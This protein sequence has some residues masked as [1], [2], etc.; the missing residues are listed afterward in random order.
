MTRLAIKVEDQLFDVELD[1]SPFGNC[2][3]TARVD[4]ECVCISLPPL[5]GSL[6][7]ANWV[8]VNDRPYEITV[9]PELHWIQSSLGTFPLEIRDLG[10]LAHRLCRGNGVVKAPIPGKVVRLLVEP[11]QPVAAGQALVILEAMKMENQILAS[12]EGVVQSVNVS[13]G[14]H[15]ARGDILVEVE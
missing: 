2:H 8:V 13:C 4:G 7:G 9:D 5:N 10:A 15:V 6:E 12:R 11:G 14:D 3:L 1:L